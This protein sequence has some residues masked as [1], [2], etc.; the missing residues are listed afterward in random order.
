METFMKSYIKQAKF[1][2]ANPE[3]DLICPSFKKEFSAVEK[4]KSA[5]LE[6]SALGVYECKING[7]RVGDAYMAP[8]WTVYQKRVLFDTY[9]VTDMIKKNNKITVG[10]GHGWYASVL[11]WNRTKPIYNTFPAFALA[12]HMIYESGKEETV[13]TDTTWLA[14]KS[15]ILK[16]QIYNGE[17]VDARRST[18]YTENAR[19]FK[20]KGAI[21]PSSGEHVRITERVAAK[22]IITTPKGECV[23]DFGQNI[24]GCVEFTIKNAKGG[25]TVSFVHGEVLDKEGNFYNENYRT[26]DPRVVYTAKAG[27]QTYKATYTF[28]GFR[29]VKINEWCEDV[30][31][32]NFTAIVMHTDMKRTGYFKCGNEKINKLYENAIWGNRGNFLDIPTDCPQRDERLGWTADIQVFC[33]TA[34]IN[35]DIE[36]F[37]AKWLADVRNDQKK[38]GRIPNYIPDITLGKDEFTSSGWGDAATVCPWELYVAYG[39]KKL[40]AKHYPLMRDWLEYIHQDGDSEY[41]WLGGDRFVDWL[42]MD[43]PAGSYKGSTDGFLISSAFYYYSATLVLKAAKVLGK[44]ESEIKYLENLRKNVREAFI[45]EYVIDGNRLKGD[46]QTAYVLAIHFGLCEGRDDLC[47]AFAKRLVELIENFGDRLQTGF[48]GTPYLLDTLTD[49]GYADKAYTLLLQE[50]FPSWLFSVNHGATTIWEHWDG[51]N[52][53]GDFWS[54]DMNSFNHYAYGSVM[55]WVYRR[56]CGICAVEE[57]PAYAHINYAPIPNERLG[58]VQAS[59]DTRHGTISSSWVCEA[60]GVRYTLKLPEGTTA[61][62][63]I[64]GKTFEV[65]AGTHTFWGKR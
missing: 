25:E 32:E 51:M 16:S 11:G 26:A 22:E 19:I 49:M 33:R 18:K 54:T 52:E 20:Y 34:A 37:M 24:T 65:G 50:A 58:F 1:I 10:L 39:D 21:C 44:P 28:Y 61:T 55:A 27:E 23:I 29:Y 60:D 46:T 3:W 15:N 31:P 9:D 59:V 57:A 63:T 5:T 62:A 48:L 45:K 56:A 6:I 7:T 41:L 13:F 2:S 47:Q 14:G 4:V 64:D 8:G 38:N 36:A 12:L 42:A 17:V 30:L 40:L 35:Y 53:D 43:A